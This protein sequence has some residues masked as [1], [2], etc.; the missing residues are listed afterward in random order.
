MEEFDLPPDLKHQPLL[1]N[2]PNTVSGSTVSNTELSEFFGAHGA[3]GSELSELLSA[4][5]LCAKAN[6]PSFSPELTEFAA[7]LCEFSLPKQ[8]SRNSI[9]SVPYLRTVRVHFL[10]P[11]RKRSPAKG[12][13]RKSDETSDRSIRKIDQ[14]VTERV[15]PPPKKVIELLLPT[16]F[17]GTLLLAERIF[18]AILIFELPD[19]FADCVAGIFVVFFF[20]GG[21]VPRKILQENRR[22]NLPEFR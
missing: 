4:Y 19:L 17:C 3:P 20:G 14:K 5:D 16:S 15:P 11:C 22:Q 13:W 2:E 21:E 1:G 6:S 10:S 12:V 8:Y 9:P 7:E 18:S